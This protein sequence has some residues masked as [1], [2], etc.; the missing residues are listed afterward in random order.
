MTFVKILLF[1]A[2]VG[3]AFYGADCYHKIEKAKTELQELR[4]E[5]SQAQEALAYSKDTWQKYEALKIKA[6]QAAA[7][8][9]ALKQEQENGEKNLKAA[10]EQ[11]TVLGTSMNNAANKVRTNEASM[12]FPEIKLTDGRVLKD[13]KVRKVE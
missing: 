6:D 5:L 11:F 13:A 1:L 3:G 4:P 7:T 12:A 2:A 8:T 10:L 9:A